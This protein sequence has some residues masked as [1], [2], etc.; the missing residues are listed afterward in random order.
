MS[1]LYATMKLLEHGPLTFREFADITGWS[2]G[3]CRRTLEI[4]Q[5]RNRIRQHKRGVWGL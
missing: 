5:S 4:L 2:A 1:R 3:Q